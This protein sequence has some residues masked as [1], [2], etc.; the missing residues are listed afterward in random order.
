M[1]PA[2]C[3]R[4]SDRSQRPK[5]EATAER[6]AARK[7]D[8]GRRT[9]QGHSKQTLSDYGRRVRP[10]GN[11]EA[12]PSRAFRANLPALDLFPAALWTQ[13][14]ARRLRRVSM[15]LLMACDPMGHLP[16]REAVASYLSTSRGVRCEAGQ[17]AILSGVQEA[18][19]LSARLVYVT[20]GRQCFRWELR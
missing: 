7:N 2:K 12:R 4:S 9:A 5:R 14:A 11:L 15:N 3:L 16:L 18:L 13:V 10:F 6:N 20:P 1:K 17:V 8:A 19:D